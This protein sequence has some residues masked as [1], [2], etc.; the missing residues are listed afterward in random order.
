MLTIE[1]QANRWVVRQAEHGLDQAE[2]AVLDAWC[3]ADKRH[4]GAFGRALALHHAIVNAAAQP[5]PALPEAVAPVGQPA[6]NGVQARRRLFGLA[7]LAAGIAAAF[8]AVPHFTRP[9][10]V[11]IAT[12]VGEFRRVPLADQSIANIN[13][14]SEIEVVLTD[15]L[16]QVELKQGEAWFE[17]A[18]D[19]SRP[20]VVSAGGARVR[21]VGTSFSVHRHALGAEI[22]VTEGVVEVWRSGS[23]G[24]KRL[25]AAGERAAV[26]EQGSAIAIVRDP[27]EITR[28]LAWREGKLVF[29]NQA[30]DLAVA[31]FNRY[32][33]KQ[34]VIADP[35]L[36]ARTLIG[37]YRIDDPEQFARSVGMLLNA[38]VAVTHDRIIVGD[39]RLLDAGGSMR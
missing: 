24:G 27:E 36:A 23:D 19:K 33:R 37:Q 38:P 39:V 11:S 4:R 1:Q 29:T 5:V 7:A 10:S 12:A 32:T 26:P 21:A 13:S 17:V 15:R 35:K 9:S 2:Q 18:K 28:S 20:F 30:L 22:L 31:D 8:V 3:A 34:I 25:V 6:A 16:R 14:G